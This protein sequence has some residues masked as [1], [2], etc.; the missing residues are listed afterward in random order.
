MKRKKTGFQE[1]LYGNK[2]EVKENNE[3]IAIVQV[4]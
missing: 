3:V 4:S 1:N 2:V